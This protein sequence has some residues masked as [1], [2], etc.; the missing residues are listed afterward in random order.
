MVNAGA[1]GT[2]L[3]EAAAAPQHAALPVAS[4]AHTYVA[5]ALTCDQGKVA[6]LS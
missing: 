1:C 6:R 2:G 4:I 5:P 3:G